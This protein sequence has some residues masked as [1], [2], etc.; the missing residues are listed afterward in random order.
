[1]SENNKNNQL[2][3]SNNS[4][5]GLSIAGFVL[6]IISCFLN[7]FGIIGIVAVVLSSI[8]LSQI[9]RD[10]Q[11]GKALAI[12]GIVLGT[13]NIIFALFVFISFF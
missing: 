1:M 12:I 5:N 2:E 7:F 11:K 10:Y 9:S 6:G 13:I 4:Y 3:N 8:G